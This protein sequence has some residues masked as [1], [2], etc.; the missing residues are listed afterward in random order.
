MSRKRARRIAARR[1]KPKNRLSRPGNRQLVALVIDQ[2]PA[3]ATPSDLAKRSDR[4]W[5]CSHLHRS[6]RLRRMIAGE[7]PDGDWVLVRQLEPGVRLR[8]PFKALAQFPSGE[9]PEHVAH[10]MYDLFAEFRSIP[11]FMHE[12]IQRSRMYEIADDREDPSHDAPRRL[13]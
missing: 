9:A 2:V 4:D 10:A 5:F 12:I 6:H 8:L 1:S 3:A 7:F 13:H 11:V